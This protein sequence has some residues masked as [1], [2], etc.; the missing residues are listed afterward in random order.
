MEELIRIFTASQNGLEPNHGCAFL[1]RYRGPIVFAYFNILP[2]LDYAVIVKY[3]DVRTT[4]LSG[5]YKL[6]QRGTAFFKDNCSLLRRS[7][8]RCIIIDN[9]SKK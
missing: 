5:L 2:K 6:A 9:N 7:F 4:K 3:A 1:G 8:F